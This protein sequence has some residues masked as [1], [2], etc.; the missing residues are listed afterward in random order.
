MTTTRPKK[1]RRYGSY[2]GIGCLLVAIVIIASFYFSSNASSNQT[3]TTQSSRVPNPTTHNEFFLAVSDGCITTAST[4]GQEFVIYSLSITNPAYPT[5]DYVD[6]SI[7][8]TITLSNA[9]TIPFTLPHITNQTGPLSRLLVIIPLTGAEYA[10]GNFMSGEFEVT[11]I[12]KEVS[13]PVR[14]HFSKTVLGSYDQC[15]LMH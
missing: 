4:T 10:Q 13:E 1:K 14:L 7:N 11:V 15:P 12:Y 9:T 3:S 6:G 5:L 2:L 8:G